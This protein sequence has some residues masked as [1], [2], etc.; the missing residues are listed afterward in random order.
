MSYKI[1]VTRSAGADI[2]QAYRYISEILQNSKAADDL[3]DN[4]SR[5]I[6]SLSEFPERS[7]LIKDPVLHSWGIRYI[8]VSN[9]TVFY[10]VDD[11]RKTV[12]ILR[13]LYYRRN[14]ASILVKEDDHIMRG[15]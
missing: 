8:K 6:G 9:Y 13:F 7:S 4:V 3:L 2:L 12:F 11:S 1:S 10:T 15:E 5:S 14:W